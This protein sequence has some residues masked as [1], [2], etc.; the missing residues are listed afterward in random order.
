MKS[1]INI[2]LFVLF[3]LALAGSAMAANDGAL[4]GSDQQTEPFVPTNFFNWPDPF[5]AATPFPNTSYFYAF[6]KIFVFG[7]IDNTDYT[8]YNAGGVPIHTGTLMDGDYVSFSAPVGLY[9]LE[10][11]DLLAVLVGAADDNIVGFHALNEQSLATGTRFLSHQYR[12][13]SA[14]VQIVFAY[15]DGTTVQIYNLATGVLLDSASLDA[16]EHFILGTW[17]G[18]NKYLET[19]ANKKISVLNFSDIGYS[20]PC[21]SGLFTGTLFHGYMGQTSGTG[22]LLITSYADDNTVTVTNSDTAAVIWSGT[23]QTGQL[24]FQS[25]SNLY[26]T[27][28]SS[29]PVTVSVNPYDAT[30]PD[31]HY[32]DVAVDRTGTRIGTEFYFTSVNGQIDLFSY[33]DANGIVAYDTLGT[34]SP[35]DDVLVWSGTLGQGGH[36][37]ITAHKT[38][39]HILSTKG[40]SVFHSYGTIAGAEFIPLYG[41]II[42]CDND[43]DGYEGPQCD[44]DD[45]ND[46]DDSIHPGAEEIPC[47]GI[48]QDCDGIDPC[49][50]ENDDQCD[51][52]VFCN[53]QE[54]CNT[55]N[56]E[57]GPG[58]P[59][60]TDDELWCNGKEQCNENDDV[61]EQV[62]VP[63]CKDDG[64]FCTGD[65]FCDEEKDRCASSGNPCLDDEIY[66]NGTEACDENND[67]CVHSGDP[68]TDDGQHCNGD[69]SCNEQSDACDHSGDPCSDDGEYCNGD[70]YCIETSDTCGSTGDPCAAVG[71]DCNE[72]FDTCNDPD[73]TD[74]EDSPPE[75][76][77][78]DLWPKGQVTGGCCGCS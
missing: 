33:E 70:E 77:E 30:T 46:W 31:Y 39:W 57:C 40:L 23:L 45:C 63:N 35:A 62:Q 71:L 16:G 47:D 27:V 5:A 67:A 8:I 3:A 20:V 24:W 44:G 34:P 1:H 50:C 11:S 13:S 32:M 18:A 37:L 49:D 15:E 74:D 76:E 48:D 53:G 28:E 59:P 58:V 36:H 61:C 72:Q 29:D 26:F 19:T 42:D 56:G 22:D 41:I 10:A 38:Q 68:C 65:E 14:C 52:D 73:M 55:A 6:D 66:C 75:E 54:I 60:C 21:E 7:Y 9:R 25:Y 64:R 51:D 69:E 2:L 12:S 43:G 4:P 78:E 17:V